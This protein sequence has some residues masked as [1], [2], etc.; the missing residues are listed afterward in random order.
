MNSIQFYSILFDLFDLFDF[1]IQLF[2]LFEFFEL[3][4]RFYWHTA[5]LESVGSRVLYELDPKKPVLYVVPVES[6]IGK[7]P[8]VPVGDFGS[9]PNGM[10][11]QF[12]NAL[13]DRTPGAGDG[14]PVWYV[15]SWALGWSRET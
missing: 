6:I 1:I 10:R 8:V 14:C 7:L 12:P 13:A 15:N 3:F 4:D 5:W 9:V 2:D 11:A